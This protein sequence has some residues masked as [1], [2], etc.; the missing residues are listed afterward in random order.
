M[1]I[2][3]TAKQI[4][5]RLAWLQ[6]GAS[7][8]AAANLASAAARYL[9]HAERAADLPPMVKIDISPVCSLACPTCL[10]ADP[11]GRDRPLLDRQ[12]FSPS[13]RMSREQFAAIIEQI[14]GRTL[15]VSLYYFGDPLAHPQFACFARIAS[16]AGLSTHAST[17]FSYNLSDEKVAA[18]V[19]SGLSHLT[20]TVDGASQQTYGVTRV[21]GR[22]DWVL[23][24]LK[25]L[26]EAKRRLDRSEP[27]IEVQYLRHPHH[28]VD[29]EERVR[30]IALER[31]ADRVTAYDGFYHDV[32]G[33]LFNMVDTDA[34]ARRPGPALGGALLPRCH[35]P[36]TGTVI[37]YD[38]EVIPCCKWREGRQYGGGDSRALGNVFETPLA[39]IWNGES[40]RRLRRQ[41]SDPASAAPGSFCE[42]CPKCYATRSRLGAWEAG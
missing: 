4:R 34:G 40:Y 17:H 35:W 20:V 29:E 5:R 14:R 31:G 15:A 21:R 6:R 38:G 23:N 32:D 33:Q 19:E 10:H 25:R 37:K 16:E 26:A 1:S 41:A 2:L 39:E 42:G 8:G 27:V 22:L 24:N 30:A 28:A 9:L 13:Q 11:K 12:S 36:Y 7:P 18:I 3:G